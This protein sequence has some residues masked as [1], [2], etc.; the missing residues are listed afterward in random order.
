MDAYI[1]EFCTAKINGIITQTPFNTPEYLKSSIEAVNKTSLIR[2][3]TDG[4]K[5][6]VFSTC[7][8][9]WITVTFC[10]NN[11]LPVFLNAK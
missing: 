10:T 3:R 9:F 4:P 6:P 1:Q 8:K 7:N 2:Y 11:R 5:L